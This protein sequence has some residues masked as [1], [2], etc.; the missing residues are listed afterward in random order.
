MGTAAISSAFILSSQQTS[1]NSLIDKRFQIAMKTVKKH[2]GGFSD[3]KNDPGGFTRYGVSLR[4]LKSAKIDID[5][6]GDVDRDDIIHLTQTKADDIY[7]REWYTKHNYDKIESQKLLTDILDFSINVGASQC[8]KTLKRAINEIIDKPIP[9]D[10]KFDKNT[11]EILNLIEPSVM[12]S[13][14]NHQQEKFYKSLVKKNPDLKV[15]LKGWLRRAK[16]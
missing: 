5:G 10:G 1:A 9:V 4:Y 16:E 12:H 13:A 15:F 8:H 3:N 7:Y 2:E 14:L 11:I 6:D